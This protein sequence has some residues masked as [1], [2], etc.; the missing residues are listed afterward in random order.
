MEPMTRSQ[1]TGT[2]GGTTTAGPDHLM[3]PYDSPRQCASALLDIFRER[4]RPSEAV[5]VAVTSQVAGCAQEALAGRGVPVEY[6]DV[7][8]LGRNPARLISAISDLA[9]AGGGRVWWIEEPM[10]PG[11]SPAEVAEVA[12][13][14]ALVNLAF[15]GAPVQVVCVYNRPLLSA[16]ELRYGE[17][18]HPSLWRDGHAEASAGY[19]GAGEMPAGA[20][21]PLDPP[22]PDAH[23]ISYGWALQPVRDAV[24]AAAAAAG[25]AGDRARDL[26]LAVHEA[27]ANS[28]RHADGTGVLHTWRAA[29]EIICDIGDSG[30]VTD[31]LAGRRRSVADARGHGLWVANQVCDLVQVR[32]RP[33]RTTVRLH[34]RASGNVSVTPARRSHQA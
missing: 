26:V 17:S 34:M 22:P 7:A 2:D 5:A 11:R 1:V 6:V 14:E 4:L 28:L 15:T 9:T 10:W 25:V 20:D 13:H 30:T 29:G 23:R 31:P 12:R 8:R 32:S 24:E 18:T 21:L 16:A 19:T 27:A 3:L 33:G